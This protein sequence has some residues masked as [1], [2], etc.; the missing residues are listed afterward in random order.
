MKLRT[1]RVLTTLAAALLFLAM[2]AQTGSAQVG[3]L[4]MSIA[5]GVLVPD[6]ID[7]N[8]PGILSEK[9]EVKTGAGF[10]LAVGYDTPIGLRVEGEFGYGRT[11]FGNFSGTALGVPFSGDASDIDINIYTFSVNAFYGFT[12]PGS[13]IVPWLGG[14][15]GLGHIEQESGTIIEN[16]IAFS[17]AS[18]STTDF[19]ANGQVGI[20]FELS[21]NFVIVPSYRFLWIN[22]GD[23]FTDDFIAHTFWL[24]LRYNFTVL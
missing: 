9:D 1:C 3:N 11:S 14:G 12:L 16:G 21:K 13:P 15:I 20:D 10:T 23:D 6:D 4:Y 17:R 8:V 19:S 18:S 22:S 5:G 2:T 7:T 24:G